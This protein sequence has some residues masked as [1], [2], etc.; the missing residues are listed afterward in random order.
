MLIKYR[1]LNRNHMVQK[2][3][4]NTLSDTMT[5]MFIRPL[6]IRLP[7]MTGYVRDFEGNTTK[8]S[9]ISHK[10]L[11]KKCNQIWR[12]IEK[13]L[14]IE[15]YSEPVYGNNNNYIKTKN[16]INNSSTITS[17]H[18]KKMPKE[19][20]SCKTLSI[21]I[22]DS[23]IKAKKKYYPQTLLEECKYEQ[24]KKIKMENLIDDDLEKS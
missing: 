3:H 9:K 8:F 22:L 14:K 2:I 13:V 16:K 7:Q 19:K 24:Q 1:S 5:M 12:R 10:Q 18:S 4:S 11:L 6:Y 15:F 21:I 20:E 17:L 23:V